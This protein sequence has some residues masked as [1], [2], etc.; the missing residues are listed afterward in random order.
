MREPHLDVARM[1]GTRLRRPAPGSAEG[2]GHALPPAIA[3]GA[4]EIDD[5]VEGAGD[6]VDELKFDDRAQADIGGSDGRADKAFLRQR[7]FDDA[8][9]AELVEKAFGHLES[10]A[11][12]ADVLPHQEDGL[13]R[14]HLLPDAPGDRL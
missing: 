3:A 1:E 13:V 4:G 2:D 12:A 10:A 8:L 14:F 5:G 9:R 6:E 11:V 7:G